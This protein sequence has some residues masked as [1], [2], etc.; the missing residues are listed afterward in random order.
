MSSPTLKAAIFDLDGTLLDTLDGIAASANHAIGLQGASP[1]DRDN[2][3]QRI[4]GGARNLFAKLPEPP[5]DL[6]KAVSD[7]TAHQREQGLQHNRRYLGVRELLDALTAANIPL[8]VLSN[9]PHAAVAPACTL[10]DAWPFAL[11]QGADATTAPKPDPAGLLRVCTQLNVA[12]D[13]AAYFGDSE[14]DIAVARSAGTQALACAWGFRPAET[15][16]ALHPDR[17]LRSPTDALEL[18]GLPPA[19]PEPQAAREQFCHDDMV[20]LAAAFYIDLKDDPILGPMYPDHDL[21]GAQDRLAGFFSFRL[22]FDNT[23]VAQRGHP[24]LRGRHTPFTVD[25]PARDAWLKRMHRA[26]HDTLPD[27]DGREQLWRFFV[28]LAWFMMNA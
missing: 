3:Q 25:G 23:Y 24:R 13:E 27:G 1:L 6:D 22:G 18:F 12:P 8:A 28:H 9:K 20:R 2:W 26:M 16:I 14:V 7:Y 17:L 10:L 15:L 21:Q 19:H 4:G 11:L 5:A